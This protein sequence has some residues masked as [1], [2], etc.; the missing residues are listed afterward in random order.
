MQAWEP[1]SGVRVSTGLLASGSVF[2]SS[3]EAK[4]AFNASKGA[5]L[6]HPVAVEMENA[7]V[8]QICKAYDK[9]Y[10]SLRALSDLLKGDANA[11]FNAF[12]TRALRPG[13]RARAQLAMNPTGPAIAAFIR[14]HWRLLCRP[15]KETAVRWMCIL[16]ALSA[17][18][19][20]L[21]VMTT[22]D[23]DDEEGVE[24]DKKQV[25]LYTPVKS[26]GKHT[27]KVRLHPD[28]SLDFEFEVV[29]E[30][31]IEEEGESEA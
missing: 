9:P 13:C 30:N 1:P 8:A 23:A 6:G 19:N 4:L 25:S 20:D 2:I 3:E 5:A 24:L 15:A 29:S 27:T 17:C 28:V 7:G 14:A 11:D 21:I 10:L 12:F 18:N 16:F 26:L 22:D 31:P